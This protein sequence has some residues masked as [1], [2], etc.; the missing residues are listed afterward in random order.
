[1]KPAIS[2]ILAPLAGLVVLLVLIKLY[3]VLAVPN[4]VYPGRIAAFPWIEVGLAG[5]AALIGGVVAICSALVKVLP[6]PGRGRVHARAVGL[7]LVL[8]C[9]LSGLDAWLRIGDINVGLPLAP[10]FYLWGGISQELLTHFLPVAVVVG[11][12]A[13][14]GARERLQRLGFVAVA[15]AMSG[16]AAM[17]MAAAFRLPD[18]GLVARVAAAPMLVAAAVFAIELALFEMFRRDGIVAALAMRLGFYAVWHI[19]WPAVAY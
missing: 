13:L 15:V 7:G 12:L 2:R 11:L 5:L 9:G 3:D 6:E 17:S 16:L 10:V 14:A 19:A 18:I 4:L 8:G 1:M